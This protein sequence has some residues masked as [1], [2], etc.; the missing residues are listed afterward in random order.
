MDI[1]LI[2]IKILKY[3]EGNIQPFMYE[4]WF[5]DASL[6]KLSDKEAI[7]EVIHESVK[8]QLDENYREIIEDAFNIVTSTN[9]KIK[10]MTKTDIESYEK[11]VNVEIV[12]PGV[13]FQSSN[14]ANLNKH[15]TFDNFVVGESNRIAYKCAVAVAE[16]PGTSYNP[17]FV[18]GNSGLGKTHLIQAIGNYAITNKRKRVLYVSSQQFKEEF[19]EA[20]QRDR[21]TDS[22]D[23]FKNKYRHV[24]VLIVDDI[25]F[26][27]KTE[28]TQE[29]FFHTFNVLYDAD[30]QIVISADKSPKELNQLEDRLR[31]RFSWGI[32]VNI[33]PPELDLRIKIL[34]KKIISENVDIFIP[35]EIIGFIAAQFK[36][37]VRELEGALRLLLANAAIMGGQNEIDFEF[38]MHALKTQIPTNKSGLERVNR[39]INVVS[40]YYNITSLEIKGK[41]RKY[42]I[43][44]PRQIAMYL[45]RNITDESFE[46]IGNAFG[47]RHHSTVMNSCSNIEKMIKTD[48][49]FVK[50]IEDLKLNF[51]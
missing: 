22:I 27:S 36:S 34:K 7:I 12:N 41:S 29:E 23:K 1:R 43:Q 28:K 31:T 20:L 17:F 25:Q 15:Y 8:K 50:T 10:V 37:D 39:I 30:K 45:S 6:Y 38:A 33:T 32:P 42:S 14:D 51:K 48:V 26:L 24:D 35:D 46:S 44:L 5:E 2:W 49:S 40:E 47:G 21:S 11:N 4:T 18:Y 16:N 3:I 19:I 9:F 13:P